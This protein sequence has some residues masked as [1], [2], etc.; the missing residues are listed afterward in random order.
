VVSGC[1]SCQGDMGRAQGESWGRN[2]ESVLKQMLG[3]LY[4]LNSLKSTELC[5]LNGRLRCYVNFISM[6]YNET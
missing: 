5:T 4:N 6:T 1:Q 3:C 2:E